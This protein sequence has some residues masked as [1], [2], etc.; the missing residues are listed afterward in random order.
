[1]QLGVE[2]VHS[3][4]CFGSHACAEFEAARLLAVLM[5]HEDVSTLLVTPGPSRDGAVSLE[6]PLH[7][8]ASS[9][10]HLPMSASRR[11]PRIMQCRVTTGMPGSHIEVVAWSMVAFAALFVGVVPSSDE[12]SQ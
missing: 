5:A 10:I 4:T 1:M 12:E 2:V 7:K 6:L 9:S 3:R 11:I 8:P